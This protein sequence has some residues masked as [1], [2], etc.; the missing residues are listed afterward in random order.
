MKLSKT[1]APPKERIYGSKVNP[2]ESSKDLKTSKNIQFDAKT[3]ATI[4]K[5]VKEHNDEHPQKKIS[6]TSAKS[7]VRRGMGA[8]SSTHR[9]TIKGGKPNSRVAWGLARLNAFTYK[10]VHGKS[11]SGK[12]TQDDDLINELGYSVKKYAKGGLLAPNGKPSNLTAEQYKLVRTPEFK[13]W[14]GDWEND[15]KNASKVVDDNGEPLVVYHG[16]LQKF[17]VFNTHFDNGTWHGKGAYFTSSLKDLKTNYVTTK[18]DIYL[19]CYLNV[20]KPL[21]VGKKSEGTW[22]EKEQREII[23]QQLIYYRFPR[24][25]YAYENSWDSD[26]LEKIVRNEFNESNSG[27]VL[28]SI[29]RE[30]GFDG[31]IFLSPHKLKGHTAPLK[32]KHFVCFNSNQ[33]KL[34]DGSNTTFDGS[35]PD[36]RYD[37]GENLIVEKKILANLQILMKEFLYTKQTKKMQIASSKMDSNQ[38]RIK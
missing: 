34:A 15:P 24:V 37:E 19:Q 35:K 33:I 5:K 17:T 23:K 18:N 21:V 36:I 28:N 7:V 22:F 10:I 25:N 12:Y 4:S 3:I 38:K 27:Q 29:Y 11:K 32:T 26:N 1:P 14:F 30:L 8:Y 6:I 13:A 9:P 2:K 20:R 16:T 31:I